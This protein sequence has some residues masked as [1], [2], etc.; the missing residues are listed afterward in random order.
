MRKALGYKSA[1]MFLVDAEDNFH[2]A[3]VPSTNSGSKLLPRRILAKNLAISEAFQFVIVDHP[4]SLHERI[5]DSRANEL[6]PTPRKVPTK[7]IRF[8]GDSLHCPAA[9]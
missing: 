1:V 2:R 8:R 6:Q 3:I 7:R 9:F 4:D 5:T